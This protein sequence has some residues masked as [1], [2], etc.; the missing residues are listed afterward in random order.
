MH[1]RAHVAVF[2]VYSLAFFGIALPYP[3]VTPMFLDGHI[4]T[5]FE[6]EVALGIVM[7]LY[8]LGLF[9][10]GGT[11][12]SLSDQYG[13]RPV[14]IG[15]LLLT[16]LG[17]LWSAY[18]IYTG[19]FW[20]LVISRFVT[21]FFEANGSIARAMIIDM[22]EGES[23]ATSFALLSAG[24]YGGY[25]LGP[26]VGGY[27]AEYGNTVPFIAAT[28]IGFFALVLAYVWLP[29][30]NAK[31]AAE[32]K[33]EKRPSVFAMLKSHAMFR[34]LLLAH[35]LLTIGINTF[36]QFYPMFLVKRWGF[37][38]SEIA[39]TN[40][41]CTAAMIGFA[42][43]G[44]R[45]LEH[46]P[47][48]RKLMGAGAIYAVLLVVLLTVPTNA[49]GII[50]SI[51]IGFSIA[52]L[53]ATAPAFLSRETKDTLQQ[54]AVMGAL[55]SSFCLAQVMISLVGSKVAVS[56]IEITYIVGA[57]AVLLGVMQ[58]QRVRTLSPAAAK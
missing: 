8:P 1:S 36:Y 39:F 31:V 25:L 32:G 56:G 44:V 18:S 23:T 14:L 26:I 37:G 4:Q 50:V 9:F 20:Q 40:M 22:E 33:Q 16:T 12:G 58:V 2:V 28:G 35:F 34:Q 54:G 52:V 45:R 49:M 27:L 42:V 43:F 13:R 30:T 29:E 3:V 7:A 10:G 15:S 53:N 11:L 48:G 47:L 24:A 46:F 17:T 57:V 19:D 55:T 6:P 41:F 5:M 51:F 21:G 38:P